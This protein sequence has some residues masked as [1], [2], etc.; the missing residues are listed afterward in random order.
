VGNDTI[1]GGAGNDTLI[2]G[3]GNDTLRGGLGNDTLT[4]GT[5]TDQFR[6]QSN[7]GT[8]TITDMTRGTDK[9]GFLGGAITGGVTFANTVASSPGAALNTADYIQGSRTTIASLAASDSNKVVEAS[10]AIANAATG[11]TVNAVLNTYVILYTGTVGQIWFDAD[12]RDTTGRLQIATLSNIT[13]NLAAITSFTNT[14][15]VVYGNS[16][17]TITGLTVTATGISYTATDADKDSL[18]YSG[19]FIGQGSVSTG[20]LSTLTATEQ[21][22]LVRQGSVQIT[23]GTATTPVGLE[24]AFGTGNGDNITAGLSQKSALYGFG[25]NDTFNFAAGAT[26]LTIADIVSGGTG[27]DTV[28]LTG[29]TLISATDFNNVSS[30]EAITVA[31]VTQ[32]VSITTVDALVDSGATLMLNASGLTIGKLTFNGA[33]ETNGAFNITGGAGADSITGGAGNDTITGGAGNDM[34]IGGVGNDTI[35]SGLGADTFIWKLGDG[36]SIGIPVTDAITDFN[37]D[38]VA[39]GGDVLDLRDLLV[40]ES[41][42]NLANFLHFEKAGGDTV[43]HVSA[44][45]GFSG[46]FTAVADVQIITLSA[47]DLVTGFANDQAIITDLLSKQK[48]ITD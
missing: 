46:G 11:T 14:D 6:L 9:I 44:T 33:A 3:T 5:N 40:G 19:A 12:W 10:A 26:G 30:I 8:D 28:A 45:G 16:A 29:D 18:N 15:F 38:S 31:N 41:A 4:G 13:A 24:A 17:A 37:L 35:T 39:L 25:G 36:G 2:G 1:T 48:L 22:S 32:N 23:D 43:V 21:A 20:T 42:G 47:V 34:L 7:G 27:T